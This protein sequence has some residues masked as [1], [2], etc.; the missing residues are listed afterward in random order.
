MNFAAEGE[1]LRKLRRLLENVGTRNMDAPID[2]AT[3]GFAN[4]SRVELSATNERPKF[5]EVPSVSIV[6]ALT[7]DE[8]IRLQSENISSGSSIKH[9]IEVH[10]NIPWEGQVYGLQ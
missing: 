4:A 9:Q 10:C 7:G 1:R 8:L 3:A 2:T 5:S 6:N